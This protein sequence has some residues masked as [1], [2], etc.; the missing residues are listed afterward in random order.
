MWLGRWQIKSKHKI[1]NCT[2]SNVA[3]NNGIK[4]ELNIAITL[5]AAYNLHNG[6]AFKWW[7]AWDWDISKRKKHCFFIGWI[8]ALR[9]LQEQTFGIARGKLR[10]LLEVHVGNLG[11]QWSR[12]TIYFLALTGSLIS[13]KTMQTLGLVQ[14]F[15]F[16]RQLNLSFTQLMIRCLSAEN[17]LLW[18]GMCMLAHVN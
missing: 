8:R 2:V 3:G 5:T 14:G 10:R 15:A 17:I 4:K 13:R 16:N 18:S 11:F 6:S 7:L 12:G 1:S 9:L